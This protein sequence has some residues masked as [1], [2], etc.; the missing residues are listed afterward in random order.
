MKIN[1]YFLHGWGF[2]KSFW[3]PVGN[4]IRKELFTNSV[5]YLDLGFFYEKK[6]IGNYDSSQK[7]IFIVHSLGLNWFLKMKIDC[8]S[9]IN[10]FSAPSFLNFQIDSEK[11]KRYLKKMI[12]KFYKNPEDVLSEFYFNCGIE[13]KLYQNHKKKDLKTLSNSL[14]N[15]YQDNQLNEFVEKNFKIFSIYSESDKIFQ[16]SKKNISNLNKKNHRIKIFKNLN[17][18]FPLTNPKRTFLIIKSIIN[19]LVG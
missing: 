8:F 2:D 9:L 10:F 3:Y 1:F 4:L 19:K 12:F 7:N 5:K 18:A 17:H 15:L 6:L 13:T 16:P 11:K 14:M